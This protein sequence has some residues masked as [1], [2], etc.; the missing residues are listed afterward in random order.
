MG[1][2]AVI[3]TGEQNQ[4]LGEDLAGCMVEVRV[5][6]K[7]DEPTLFAIRFIEDIVDGKPV[8]ASQP[9]LQAGL[10]RHHRRRGRK[11][12][13]SAWCAARDLPPLLVARADEVIE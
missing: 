6:Q 10:P 12:G 7:L 8:K 2:G 4:L 5:E 11:A 13:C 3:G 9:T 1:F